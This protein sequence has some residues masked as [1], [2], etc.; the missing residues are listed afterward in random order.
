[1]RKI[2][3]VTTGLTLVLSFVGVFFIG[4]EALAECKMSREPKLNYFIST[5]D[6]F[7][8]MFQED[9]SKS[10]APSVIERC[11]SD[12]G[13]YLMISQGIYHNDILSSIGEIS[14]DGKIADTKCSVENSLTN[15]KP[16]FAMKSALV[17]QQYR[18]LRAC[19]YMQIY[20]LENKSINFIPDQK[21]CKVTRIGNG[22]LRA[23]GDYC[24][25]KI[26][27]LNRFAI[28]TIVKEECKDANFLRTHNIDPQDIEGALNAYIA[29]DDS[30]SSTD[31][32]QLGTTRMRIYIQPHEKII[33]LTETFSIDTPRFPTEYN[34]DLNMGDFQLMGQDQTFTVNMSVEANNNSNRKCHE[35][36]CASSSDF[37]QPVVSEV[38]FKQIMRDGSKNFI[39]AWW[40]FGIVGPR[41]QGLVDANHTLEETEIKVGNRY[42]TTVTF[43]DP[44]EDFSL[45]VEAFKQFTIDL[46]STQGT[47][48]LDVIASLPGLPQL[49]ALAGLKSLP[50][51]SSPTMNDELDRI[52]AALDKLGKNRQWPA[53][54]DTVCDKNRSS[55][56]RAGKVKFFTKLTTQF[57]IGPVDP[58]TGVY[59]LENVVVKKESPVN[60]SYQRTVP[61]LPRMK[62]GAF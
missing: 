4:S 2:N 36:F 39:D 13:S 60:G 52:I 51:L 8:G 49:M 22:L 7:T 20:D 3:F 48:G 50:N 61:A 5:Q 18:A 45:F 24:F 14:F 59:T 32:T 40:H 10:P 12:A 1:M 46:N 33:P 23:E 28:T 17:Q 9:S 6:H 26:N 31:L 42:E 55:C 25:F 19:T 53:Y 38:E 56:I 16:A 11:Q 30:G 37:D 57:T 29:G 47:A 41:W 21:F 54:Y 43:V 58:E 35:G 15:S 34:V 44:Y 62:C 27:P